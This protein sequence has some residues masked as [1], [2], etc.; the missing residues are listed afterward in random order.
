MTRDWPEQLPSAFYAGLDE[1]NAGEYYRCH[2]TLEALWLVERRPV[3]EAY[4]GVLQIAVGCYHLTT[5]T[6]WIGATRKLNEGARRLERAGLGELATERYGVAWDAL[7][8][9][10]DRLH[11]HLEALGPAA[12]FQFDPA[13]LPAVRYRRSEP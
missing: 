9:A 5:R 10:A 7:I 8:A 3:R 2:E 13:L 12:V 1:L 11:S 4:Q 6:N